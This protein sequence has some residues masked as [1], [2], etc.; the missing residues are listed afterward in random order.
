MQPNYTDQEFL[1]ILKEYEQKKKINRSAWAITIPAII[2]FVTVAFLGKILVFLGTAMGFTV[3]QISAFVNE[4]GGNVIFEI[5]LSFVLMLVPYA[6]CIR[7]AGMRVRDIDVFTRSKKGTAL[8]CLLFGV[9]FCAFAN[10]AVSAA[11]EVFE[12]LG[13][14]DT[15][16]RSAD[17]QGFFGFL[18]SVIAISIVPALLEEFAFRGVVMTVLKPYGEA[19]SVVASAILFGLIHGNVNQ[20]PFAF[21]V[22]L[23]LGFIRIKSGSLI[24]PM[25]VHGINNLVSTVLSYCTGMSTVAANTVYTIYLLSALTAAIAGVALFKG[26]DT[27]S[28]TAPEREEGAKTPYFLFF[29][30]PAIIIYILLA[31]IKTAMEYFL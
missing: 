17:P 26:K 31:V 29:T 25:A 14:K 9:G 3:E 23:A 27:F 21:L 18:L 8:P 16:V 4:P 30:S 22:G 6:I 1:R 28:F 15:T 24:V 2:F 20:I 10:I 12:S 5:A 13:F 11:G 19:F 7:I